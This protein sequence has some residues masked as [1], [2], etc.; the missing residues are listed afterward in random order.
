M[1]GE[2][3]GSKD[4]P[5][6]HHP[7]L[8]VHSCW[9]NRLGP[10][11]E[12][13][14]ARERPPLACRQNTRPARSI[15]THRHGFKRTPVPHPPTA[16]PLPRNTSH[17]SSRANL[18]TSSLSS[19][20]CARCVFSSICS[21]GSE[22][23]VAG[24]ARDC[25]ER[26]C[27]LRT[28]SPPRDEE[29]RRRAG[30]AVTM[31]AGAWQGSSCPWFKASPHSLPPNPTHPA[32][33]GRGKRLTPRGL[34]RLLLGGGRAG[35]ALLGLASRPFPAG[36]VGDA[37]GLER[38]TAEWAP[39]AHSPQPDPIPQCSVP[40]CSLD[41]CGHRL[42]F[43]SLDLSEFSCPGLAKLGEGR[44]LLRPLPRVLQRG[45]PGFRSGH[46]AASDLGSSAGGR[47]TGLTNKARHRR[48][49]RQRK[50]ARPCQHGC[51]LRLSLV[52]GGCDCR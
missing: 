49:M 30:S 10:C 47:R 45:G 12:C 27:T 7:V 28:Q 48:S 34:R 40:T 21:R 52:W 17:L 37:R 29:Q 46:L 51:C 33:L 14:H 9:M 15:S 42:R 41:Q 36:G 2:V 1:G 23:Q 50:P 3:K 13:T 43:L 39:P 26:A 5:A 38:C 18:R 31:H 16:T 22:T 11:P 20:L 25:G 32:G 44:I 19:C 24:A 4:G 8:H 6:E 35:G